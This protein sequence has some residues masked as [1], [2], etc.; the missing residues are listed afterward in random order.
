MIT[1]TFNIP[2]TAQ[3]Y[4]PYRGWHVSQPLSSFRYGLAWPWHDGRLNVFLVSG[5]AKSVTSGHLTEGC[6]VRDEWGGFIR[7]TSNYSW[8]TL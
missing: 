7:D 3:V 4:A 1:D 2:P 5:G 6:D 8:D